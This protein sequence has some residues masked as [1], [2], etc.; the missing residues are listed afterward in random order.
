MAAVPPPPCRY[1]QRE[2]DNAT[3]WLGRGRETNNLKWPTIEPSI[4]RDLVGVVDAP[5][6]CDCPPGRNQRIQVFKLAVVYERRTVA[7]DVTG[8]ANP[9]RAEGEGCGRAVLPE[10]IV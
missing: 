10:K 1:R 3:G 6:T 9:P 2:H 5:A 7:D 4:S 8:A